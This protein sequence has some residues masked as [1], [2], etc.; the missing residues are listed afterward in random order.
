MGYS[1]PCVN[2]VGV[3]GASMYPRVP[4]IFRWLDPVSTEEVIA[5]WHPRGYGGYV[6]S[7]SPH[8]K[9]KKHAH[10]YIQSSCSLCAE[11]YTIEPTH[12]LCQFQLPPLLAGAHPDHEFTLLLLPR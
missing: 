4:K 6:V 9:K 8:K 10:A 12:P 5:M 1:L 3:N 11:I 7:P 2:S